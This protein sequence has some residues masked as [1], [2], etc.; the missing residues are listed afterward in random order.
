MFNNKELIQGSSKFSVKKKKGKLIHVLQ[1]F[2]NCAL[3]DQPKELVESHI[4]SKFF[5]KWI[6]NTS[7][8]DH[9]R[10]RT[11]DDNIRQDG[12]KLYLL[13]KDCEQKLSRFETYFQIISFIPQIKKNTQNL[14]MM[15]DCLN[16]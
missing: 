5:Y 4:I 16:F 15:V 1:D 8:S 12:Y 14:N 9:K 7:K 13:C 6:K 3:C 2:L 11:F 10:F